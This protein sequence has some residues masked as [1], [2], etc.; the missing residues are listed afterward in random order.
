MRGESY[1]EQTGD[2]VLSCTGGVAPTLGSV[3]PQVNITLFYS[4]AVTSR[5]LPVANASS[6]ISEALLLIDEPGSGVVPTVPNF[7]PAAPENLCTTPLQG[8]LE[9]V[10][11]ASGVPVATDT[12]Q[13]TSATTPGKN[14]FQ[15]IV[16]GN[17]V[18]FFGIPILAP[19]SG[20]RTFRITNVRLNATS[21]GNGPGSLSPAAVNISITG[22][23]SMLF[24]NPE[25]TVGFVTGSLT[26]SAANSS[27][28][29]KCN[30]QDLAP[31][32]MLSFTESFGNAF[33]TRVMAQ[34]PTAYA[35]QNGTPGAN[36]F[37]AQNIPGAVYNSESGLVV[38]IGSGQTAGLADFGTRLKAQFISV[39]AGVRIFVSVAN[40]LNNGLPVSPPAL[41]GG[42]AANTGLTGFA[43]LTSSETGAFS[44]IAPTDS[45]AGVPVV[46]LAVANGSATAVWEVINTNPNAMETVNFGVYIS[47]P[48]NTAAAGS[49]TVNLG[50]AAS[51]PAFTPDI[52]AAA[53]S[54]LAIPRFLA[55]GSATRNVLTVVTGSCTPSLSVSKTHSGNFVQGQLGVSY[56]LT[57]TN[58]SAAA[59]DGSLVT[60]TDTLPPG[61]T[62]TAIGGGGWACTLGSL[63]CTRSGVLNGG[64]SYPSVTVTVNVAG[65]ATSPQTNQAAVSGGGSSGA[66]ASDPTTVISPGVVTADSV[67]PSS[68]TGLAQTFVLRYSDSAGASAIAT[69]AVWFSA[70]FA[71]NSANSCKI[72]YDRASGM[73]ILDDDS[74][75]QAATGAPGTAGNLQNSQ[76]ALALAGSSVLAA[77]NTLTLNLPITFKTAFAGAKNIFMYAADLGSTSSG[78]LTRGSWTIPAVSAVATADRVTPAY[79]AGANQT[80]T[81]QYSDNLGAASLTSALAWFT[82]NPTASSANSC[83]VSYDR[84]SNTLSLMNDVGS[85]PI[86]GTAGTAGILQ[87]SQCSVGLFASNASAA[88][89]SLTLTL[90]M[91]FTS[92]FAG[93]KN[94]YLLAIDSGGND[95]GWQSRGSWQVP[96]SIAGQYTL[97]VVCP[98]QAAPGV[99]VAC[100]VNLTMVGAATIDSLAFTATV[101]PMGAAPALAAGQLG[102]STSEGPP[103]TTTAGNNSISVSWP[104]LQWPLNSSIQ[105]GS[106]GFALPASAI[107][108][109]SYWVAITSAS[110]S[111]SGIPLNLVPGL[112]TSISIPA[113]GLPSCIANVTV[114]P[115]VRAEGYT[116]QVGDIALTCT[117]G[118]VPAI[119]TA[120]PQA[121]VTVYFN[122][123]LTNRLLPQ[124]NAPNV[125]DALLLIDEPGSGLPP[126][127][128]GFGVA[129]PQNVCTTAT[130]GCVEYVSQKSGYAIPVATDSPQGTAATAPGRNVFQGIVNGNSVTFYGAPAL[131]PGN[132]ASRVFRITNVRVNAAMMSAGSVASGAVPLMSSISVSGP[133]AFTLTNSTPYV[134]FVTAGLTA[135][136][137]GAAS[138]NQCN[139]QALAAATTLVFSENF[140]TAF[141]TRV[142]AQN[143][144]SYAGQNG[145]P[146]ANGFGAQNVPGGIWNS[147]S[148][149]VLPVAT[150][151]T[152]GLT[153]FGT[154]LKAQFNNIPAG[155]RIFVSTVNVLN[156]GLPVQPPA[157]PGGSAANFS[158]TGFAQLTGSEAATFSTVNAAT[159]A[160]SV[161]V[162]ELT[163]ANGSA[164]AVWEVIN[165]NPSTNEN[166]RFA[167]FTSFTGGQP[168][169]GTVTVNLN[170]AAAPPSFTADTGASA[171][172]NLPI[173][174]FVIDPSAPRAVVTIQAAL[175]Q[176]ILGISETHVGNFAQGQSGA[177]YSVVVS[178]SGSTTS[179]TVTVTETLPAGLTLVSMAGTGWSCP[180][181]NTCSRIDA[182]TPGTSYPP[183]TVTVNVAANALA[184]V[185]NQVSVSGG[186][187]TSANASD[188]TTV[189]QAGGAPAFQTLSPPGLTGTSGLFTLQFFDGNGSTDLNRVQIVINDYLRGFRSC[190]AYY[191]A[192]AD[193]MYLLDDGGSRWMGPIPF[194]TAGVLTNSQCALDMSRS[195]RVR[196][197]NTL[198][199]NLFFTFNPGFVGGKNIFTE[200]MNN[201]AQS[202]GWQTVGGYTVTPGTNTPPTI[203][204]V[205][206]NA[207]SG[208][209]NLFRV[210]LSDP[211][212]GGDLD[213]LQLII[214]NGF[215]PTNSCYVYY[216]ALSGLIYLASDNPAVFLGPVMIGQPATLQNSQC[217]LRV[218]TSGVLYAGNSME[219]DLDI[220]F[221]TP[222]T[223]AKTVYAETRDRSNAGA[224][225]WVALGTWTAAGLVNQVPAVDAVAPATGAGRTGLFTV[226]YSDGNG[227][228][229]LERVQVLFNSTLNPGTGCLIQYVRG[230]NLMYLLN[231]AGTGWIGPAMVGPGGGG[232]LQNSR[233]AVNAGGTVV[234]ASGNSIQVLFP[235]T[236]W[237]PAFNGAKNIYGEATDS[238]GLSSNWHSVGTWTVQ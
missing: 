166:F 40:V 81:L 59:T 160:G 199:L 205:T 47:Y 135:S 215:N 165:T 20:T 121:D 30:A 202:L 217:M 222:F 34:N 103:N 110:A 148:N 27:S 38:P 207:G 53:S 201:S 162:V 191:T 63:S 100:F 66:T 90:A 119:G 29:G 13:G 24:G 128:P 197:G 236:F 170:Y 172:N 117:G 126:V 234:T 210:Q 96:S 57:V 93:S 237:T 228:T 25:P 145:S 102:F 36:G 179:G 176:S 194:G 11:Q 158:T 75:A 209:S 152:A 167:V 109:Q 173:P 150:G 91:S 26:V 216:A 138:L 56:T 137:T 171:S 68:G 231:D 19:G 70:T 211:D 60:V 32:T 71:G 113:S 23:A 6:N 203:N 48:A 183:I 149:F 67:T 213:R 41:P 62:A 5:L 15:G 153:D 218:G 7:G 52:A 163:V 188:P 77:G 61:L 187:S 224:N 2:L 9:Y 132:S 125:S 123:A 86:S 73:L 122:A 85:Q 54:T 98:T 88:G 120:I 196:S 82:T 21:I 229:D 195:T 18:T 64:A 97:D 225:N 174:R 156:S 134:G 39:P 161:P 99:N 155:V 78:W 80:F 178:N 185:T 55:D 206:P 16:N 235:M 141:K 127:V 28:F 181:G 107:A 114:T 65:N 124:S 10:S 164:T 87:N 33:R 42:I 51:P 83:K 147:E 129:A 112:P 115:N 212:G 31:T 106:V 200:V 111:V 230:A 198:T 190:L 169:P 12:A 105:V 219:V 139:S 108:G 4:A 45:A 133:G 46:E 189:L 35:G 159:S 43:Q 214:Q 182:L 22:A 104:S 89:N 223:G 72:S 220:A 50:Y 76:C 233:C 184:Q 221:K 142:T 14:V 69:T 94:L 157:V 238:G 58:S 101:T 175:C 44:A 180:G 74:G 144:L 1:T 37:T 204:S 92:A 168:L 130:Q 226:Q 136:A 208:S 193:V 177:T 84:S 8:C 116:E 192:N 140:G 154:R 79:G 151:Q 17:T 143:N 95:S 3:I 186:G 49:A 146:G 118:T 131:P 232:V 227:Y